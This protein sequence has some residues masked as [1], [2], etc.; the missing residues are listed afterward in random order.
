M[1]R[2]RVTTVVYGNSCMFF[3]MFGVLTPSIIIAPLPC[4]KS[5]CLLLLYDGHRS[6]FSCA[7][8]MELWKVVLHFGQSCC[9]K[10]VSSKE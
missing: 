2:A 7:Y 8:K 6:I 3:I 4:P 9:M 5:M 10:T 1:S